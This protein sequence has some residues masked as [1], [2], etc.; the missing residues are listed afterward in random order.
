MPLGG[1]TEW[2]DLVTLD[3][4]ADHKPDHVF[5]LESIAAGVPLP[6]EDDSASE[7]HCYEVLEHVG[8]QGDWRAFFAQF[9]EFWRV[10]RPGGFFAATCPSYRSMWAF[11]DP[12][13]TRV[14]C[15]GMLVFLSQAE[16]VKQ[17]GQTA[18]SDF[19]FCYRA[20]F[21]VARGPEKL[22]LLEDDLDFRFVLKAIKPSRWVA[23]EDRQGAVQIIP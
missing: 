8:R 3:H 10:L 22:L 18:M 7:I 2:R 11:G 12:S 6:F 17:I 23:P 15:S 16:Y 5:D 13:H 19:R 21:E 1:R 14:M 4:N 9:S 20:D